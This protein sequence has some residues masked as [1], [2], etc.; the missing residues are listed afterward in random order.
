MDE[1]LTIIELTRDQVQHGYGPNGISRADW[2]NLAEHHYLVTF[3]GWRL[4]RTLEQQ[5]VPIDVRKVLE[6]CMLHDVGELFGGDIS[7]PYAGI[8]PAAR[9]A[10][11]Q[12]EEENMKFI[13]QYFGSDTPYIMDELYPAIT[14]KDPSLEA[15]VAKIADY[16]EHL[17]FM[18]RKN[19]LHTPGAKE[20]S[21]KKILDKIETLPDPTKTVLG[22]ILKPL[23]AN[24]KQETVREIILRNKSA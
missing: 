3:I 7:M 2:S 5:N 17:Y 1:L 13:A 21:T 6:I 12:F 10:A 22:D 23:L 9:A 15:S 4:A 19:M 20:L 24:L 14:E 8:N 11:K 18:K 16:M